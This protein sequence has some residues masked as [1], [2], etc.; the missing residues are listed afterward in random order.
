MDSKKAH[1]LSVAAQSLDEYSL[2]Q[3]SN[4]AEE[5]DWSV[6]CDVWVF[7]RFVNHYNNC[8]FPRQKEVV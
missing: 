8:R 3:L 6:A 5:A 4:M 7:I 2:K 1:F